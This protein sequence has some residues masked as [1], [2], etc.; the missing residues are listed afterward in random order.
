MASAELDPP[1]APDR[2]P[3]LVT[4]GAGYIGSHVVLALRDHGREVVVIDD[5]SNGDAAAIPEGVEFHQRDVADTDFVRALIERHDVG[6]VMH[7]AASVSAL[8]S[9]ER[10]LDYH[11]NNTLASEALAR[12]CV[13][14]GVRQFIFSSS[15]A[16]YGESAGLPLAE[17]AAL[18]PTTP[19]GLS[20]LTTETMLAGLSAS[21]PG[22]EAVSLRY[23]NV[24]GADPFGRAGRRGCAGAGLVDRAVEAA[25]GQAPLD[26]WGA[27]YD[28]RDGAAERDYI[29]VSDVGDAQLA[30]MRYLQAGGRGVVLNCGS[31]RGRTVLEVIAALEAIIG[32][33][34]PQRSGPRRAGDVGSAVAD[35]TRLAATLRWRPRFDNLGLILRSALAWRRSG[36]EQTA[37]AGA[38]RDEMEIT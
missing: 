4:G 21:C 14:A 31:G 17:D 34:I 28:T 36:G 35:V 9:L 5:L 10:P 25:L 3:V 29:H 19:Y 1:G 24:A 8:E 26:I 12:A 15:A 16:V 6:L 23:F 20:K 13:E 27:D 2:R 37:G 22:F 38:N 32:R 30:A 7:L 18:S 11:R 33:R